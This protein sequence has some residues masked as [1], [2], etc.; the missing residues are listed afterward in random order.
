MDPNLL[1]REKWQELSRE[2]QLSIAKNVANKLDGNFQFVELTKVNFPGSF[3]IAVFVHK[4]TNTNWCLIPGAK[5]SMGFSSEEEKAAKAIINPP[6]L[7]VEEMRPV[8]TVDVEPFLMMQYPIK[9]DLACN[10]IDLSTKEDRIFPNKEKGVDV[11]SLSFDEAMLIAK[12]TAFSLPS[13]AQWEYA[14][15]GGTRTLFFFGNKI[16][17]DKTLEKYVH[18]KMIE[19]NPFNLF[20]LYFGEW[21]RDLFSSSYGSEPYDNMIHSVRGGGSIFW[22][23]QDSGEWAFCVSAMR[24]PSSDTINGLCVARLVCNVNF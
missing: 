6:P 17:D 7:T 16:P 21:C 5:F 11:V 19:P 20:G 14:C 10:Y 15:R 8:H 24:M 12:N 4:N 13:E 3:D 22:P 1:Y 2:R 18:P 23:W 9:S